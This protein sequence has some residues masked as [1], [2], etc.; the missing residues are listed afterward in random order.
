[1]RPS[2]WGWIVRPANVSWALKLR[3]TTTTTASNDFKS[4]PMPRNDE[5]RGLE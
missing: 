1:M 5:K 2:Q 3:T 4:M